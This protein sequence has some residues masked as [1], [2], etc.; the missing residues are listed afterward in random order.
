MVNKVRQM[1]R[2][3]EKSQREAAEYMGVCLCT[4]SKLER[5]PGKMTVDQ[6]RRFSEFVGFPF[7]KI[8]LPTTLRNVDER[9]DI[10]V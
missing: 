8:F 7:D 6:A 10:N 2:M 3:A 4:Y 1:R 9:S 5:N